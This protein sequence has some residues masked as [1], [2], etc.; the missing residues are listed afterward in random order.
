MSSMLTSARAHAAAAPLART[1]VLMGDPPDRIDFSAPSGRVPPRAIAPFPGLQA[2]AAT[3]AADPSH[4]DRDLEVGDHRRFDLAALNMHVS[5]RTYVPPSMAMAL[6]EPDRAAAMD[7]GA[8]GTALGP[9]R[10]HRLTVWLLL[11]AALASASIGSG[12]YFG[13]IRP[14]HI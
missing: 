6:L 12:I 4:V 7:Q 8:P 3:R 13:A 14:H 11:L 5:R 2:P 1:D 9:T 10:N